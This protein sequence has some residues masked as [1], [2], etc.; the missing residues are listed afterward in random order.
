MCV[1][2]QKLVVG[3]IWKKVNYLLCVC[4]CE[5]VW[6]RQEKQGAHCPRKKERE[7]ERGLLTTEKRGSWLF[8]LLLLACCCYCFL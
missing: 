4:E 6:G 2:I 3:V 7:G 1:C 5:R 8:V